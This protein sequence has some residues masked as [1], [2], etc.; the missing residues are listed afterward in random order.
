MR[1]G[2]RAVA[3]SVVGAFEGDDPTL[4]G[5]EARGFEGGFDGFETGVGE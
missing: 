1:G 2:E 5:G 4:S 3:E